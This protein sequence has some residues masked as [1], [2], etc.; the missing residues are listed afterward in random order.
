MESKLLKVLPPK[1]RKILALL[2]PTSERPQPM[3]SPSDQ[4]S[5]LQIEKVSVHYGAIQA[6]RDVS[7]TVNS[8][9]IVTLIGANGAGKSTIL[10][11]IS[12]LVRPSSGKV[13]FQNQT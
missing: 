6:I 12:G 10:R 8:G 3:H 2:K 9:E 1:F 13:L 5:L 4:G 7:F 11:S